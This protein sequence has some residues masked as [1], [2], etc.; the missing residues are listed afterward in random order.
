MNRMILLALLCLSVPVIGFSRTIRIR[1]H[2]TDADTTMLIVRGSTIS[3]TLFT[4]N[5]KFQYDGRLEFP[6]MVRLIF[7]KNQQSIAAILEGNESKARSRTDGAFKDIFMEQGLMSL[8][9]MFSAIS[10]TKPVLSHPFSQERYES[11]RS[12]FNPL[13]QMARVIIDSSY[14]GDTSHSSQNI[15]KMLYEKVMQIEK[16]VAVQFAIENINT[17]AGAYV[18]DRYSDIN[19]AKRLDSIYHLFNEPWR[20]QTYLKNVKE[21]IQALNAVSVGNVAP[22]FT[23][24]TNNNEPISLQQYIGKIVVLDFWGSWCKPCLEGFDK[25]KVYYD[26]YRKQVEFIG[27]ACN[28]S[29]SAWRSTI[30]QYQ[31]EWPNIFNE[32]GANDLTNRYHIQA[33]P[34]KIILDAEGK[35]VQIFVGETKEFYE[36]LDNLLK[37]D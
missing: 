23:G 4:T 25:M 13:V 11:F 37:A 12:R 10:H 17:A 1:V 5:G 15:Y 34:T 31:L 33:F 27:I 32:T 21:K 9:C 29:D 19:D 8:T 3:D 18:L 30:H 28:D 2:L 36:K 16:Q 26:R 7:V 6:E 22:I 20:K 14:S 24:S 35:I